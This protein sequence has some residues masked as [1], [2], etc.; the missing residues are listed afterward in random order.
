MK[1]YQEKLVILS[2]IKLFDVWDMVER[3]KTNFIKILSKIEVTYVKK[4][5]NAIN[6]I[7]ISLG[8][9]R[10]KPNNENVDRK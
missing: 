5:P 9:R 8:Y 7:K 3:I 4:K 1:W 10:R 6:S 2:T